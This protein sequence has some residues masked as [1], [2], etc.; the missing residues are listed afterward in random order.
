MSDQGMDPGQIERVFNALGRI[1][2]STVDIKQW[3]TAHAAE[4]RVM[5]ADITTLKTSHAR[6]KGFM[7]AFGVVG[8]AIGAVAALAADFFRH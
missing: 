3:M 1:E 6:Q 8:S 4:D 7:A 5:A 2:Q